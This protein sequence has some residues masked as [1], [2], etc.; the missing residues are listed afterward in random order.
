MTAHLDINGRTTL[1][2]LIGYA[3]HYTL[4]PAIHNAAFR[5]KGMNWVYVPLPVRPGELAEALRGLK[6]LGFRGAN[7][8]IP[9]KIE[10]AVLVDEL[11]G[12]ARL[13]GAVNTL[14]VE[15][16]KLLGYNTDVEGFKLFVEE[17]GIPVRGRA[18]LL[19]GAGGAARAVA[20]ALARE[21]LA[22]LHIL[23]RTEARALEL[24]EL[25][26]GVYPST[27]ISVG[28]LDPEGSRVLEE[29]DLAVNC[30]PLGSRESGELPVDY[31]AFREGKWAV[32]LSYGA[33]RSRFLDEAERHGAEVADGEGMLLHQAAASF[34]LW[35]G[36]PAPLEVMRSA[37][38]RAMSSGE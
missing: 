10:A 23:N 33:E 34:R 11:C 8:T 38:R 13:L 12:E 24:Q 20:L 35:T 25:L 36:Q 26:K 31:R 5:E 4:S 9:H 28:K 22:R 37:C 19:I 27:E 17:R 15:E 30:T 3:F 7:V 21:G 14:V 6:A 18:A 1:V 16:G 32:D 2:G 29:C